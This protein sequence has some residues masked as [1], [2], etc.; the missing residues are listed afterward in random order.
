MEKSTVGGKNKSEAVI[1]L[2]G[3]NKGIE[4]IADKNEIEM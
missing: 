2:K 3:E 1:I 4:E